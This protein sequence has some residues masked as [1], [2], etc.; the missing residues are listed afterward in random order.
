[1][2]VY[3]ILF[4]GKYRQKY[5]MEVLVMR[6]H[7]IVL[8]PEDVQDFVN[9]ASKSE[10]DIDIKYNRYSVDAKSFLGVYGLDLT[11]TLT[12]ICNGYDPVFESFIKKYAIAC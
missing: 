5:Y 8:S 11:K 6:F 10:I 12:V 2:L 9:A 3:D 1:M 7:K 4:W